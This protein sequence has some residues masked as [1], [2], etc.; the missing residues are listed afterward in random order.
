MKHHELTRLCAVFHKAIARPKLATCKAYKAHN[1]LA[2]KV[3]ALINA[4]PETI[5]KVREAS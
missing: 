3:A 4:H 1:K 2:K 5:A